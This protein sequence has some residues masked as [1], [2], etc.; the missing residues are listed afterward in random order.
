MRNRLGV[1]VL[2]RLPRDDSSSSTPIPPGVLR[3]CRPRN[4]LGD[5]SR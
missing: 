3:A 5:G 1:D 4:P 2:L